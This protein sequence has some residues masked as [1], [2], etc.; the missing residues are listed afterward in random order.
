M[1]LNRIGATHTM[2]GSSMWLRGQRLC[3]ST[4]Q[5]LTHTLRYL[6]YNCLNCDV[7]TK[8]LNSLICVYIMFIPYICCWFDEP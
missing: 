1:N 8:Y 5:L 2:G 6:L 7:F 4:A 3:N